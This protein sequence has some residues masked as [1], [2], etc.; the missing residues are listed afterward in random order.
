LLSLWLLHGV[1]NFMSHYSI[2]QN[3]AQ[4][5]DYLHSWQFKVGTCSSLFAMP[6]LFMLSGMTNTLSFLQ[7]KDEQMF[8]PK[9]VLNYYVKKLTRYWLLVAVNLLVALY[10]IPVFGSG[11][12]WENYAKLTSSCEQYWWT[13]LVYVNNFVP[14]GG[15][16]E[17]KCLPW[18]WFLPVTVQLSLI[19][20]I[21][22]YLYKKV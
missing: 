13:N 14:S 8:Q 7:A 2:L 10:V 1:S 5:N 19:V 11:P 3:P 12:I 16:F 21:Y 6:C 18:T 20:P 4:A 15:D 17:D 22:V 9:R